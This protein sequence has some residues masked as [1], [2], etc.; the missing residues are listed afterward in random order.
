[1]A[2]CTQSLQLYYVVLKEEM[3]ICIQRNFVTKDDNW[4]YIG[5]RQSAVHAMHR[6][7]QLGGQFDKDIHV[8]L[9]V[10]FSPL[11]VAYF[12]TTMEDGSYN[13]MPILHKICHKYTSWD[14]GVWHFTRDLPLYLI[15]MHD[16]E[17]VTSEFLKIE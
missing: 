15:D 4:Y 3:D 16:N 12:T 1:M 14:R 9:R 11:G 10:T 6:L 17:L 8:L 13:F 7:K 2:L 5:L